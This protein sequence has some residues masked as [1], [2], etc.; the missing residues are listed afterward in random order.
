MKTLVDQSV[1]YL[2]SVDL[3]ATHGDTTKNRV[4]NTE[5]VI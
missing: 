3:D 4:L 2:S 1:E 5:R